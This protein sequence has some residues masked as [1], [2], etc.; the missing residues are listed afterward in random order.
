MEATVSSARRTSTP[1]WTPG[2]LA[3]LAA[4][5]AVALPLIA[6][7]SA[8]VSGDDRR[9]GRCRSPPSGHLHVRRS[10]LAGTGSRAPAADRV[11]VR[12]R[13]RNRDAD[14]CR[15]RDTSPVANGWRRYRWCSASGL[16][17]WDCR[18]RSGSPSAVIGSTR[19]TASS[20]V[21]LAGAAEACGSVPR[22][23]RAGAR[24]ASPDRPGPQQRCHRPPAVPQWQDG[25]KPRLE[26]LQQAA[27]GRSRRGDRSRPR[28]R[29]RQRGS[30]TLGCPAVVRSL[31]LR[32]ESSWADDGTG[33]KPRPSGRQ[34]AGVVAAAR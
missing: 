28:V 5:G 14:R 6:T 32:L 1:G 13:L 17:G 7:K 20:T 33:L 4:I 15:G 12:G 18:L 24:G 8:F 30:P 21:L 27:A 26:H 34:T 29:A 3:G 11:C 16:S 19:S 10:H 25:A 22:A 23:D 9:S 2:R 31:H